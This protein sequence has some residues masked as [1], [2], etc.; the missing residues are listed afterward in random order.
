MVAS[1]INNRNE[2]ADSDFWGNSSTYTSTNYGSTDSLTEGDVLAWTMRAWKDYEDLEIKDS[3]NKC[4]DKDDNDELRNFISENEI[5]SGDIS[6]EEK[7]LIKSGGYV[8]D[9]CR[10]GYVKKGTRGSCISCGHFHEPT[11]LDSMGRCSNTL[12]IFWNK[13]RKLYWH[14]QSVKG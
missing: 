6:E 9:M 13:V 3:P 12:N 2:I 1:R 10:C 11:E 4:D 8:E 5:R 7:K 14:R